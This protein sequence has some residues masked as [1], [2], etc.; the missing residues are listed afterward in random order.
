MKKILAGVVALTFV[1]STALATMTTAEAQGYGV[2]W[3]G[4]RWRLGLS[5]LG[6]RRMGLGPWG[7]CGWRSNRQRLGFTLLRLRTRI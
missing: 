3:L 1:G 7:V 4:L 2:S 5:R 6:I